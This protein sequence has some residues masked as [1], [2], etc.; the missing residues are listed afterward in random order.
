MIEQPE[1]AGTSD[2]VQ[3]ATDHIAEQIDFISC[4]EKRLY[5]PHQRRYLFRHQQ[6]G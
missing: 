5:L 3:S 1:R 2:L 4:I 6:A